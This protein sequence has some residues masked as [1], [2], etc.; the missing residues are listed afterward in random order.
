MKRKPFIT[1]VDFENNVA[2]DDGGHIYPIENYID[3][4]GNPCLPEEATSVEV[5]IGDLN[6]ATVRINGDD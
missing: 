4:D 5:R 3:C 2:F 6:Y 1:E